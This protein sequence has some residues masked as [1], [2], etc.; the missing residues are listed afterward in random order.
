MDPLPTSGAA[1]PAWQGRVASLEDLAACVAALGVLPLQAPAPWPALAAALAPGVTLTAAW[2]WAGTL[3]DRREVFSGRVLPGLAAGCLAT[4][5]VF[6]LA[7]A[8]GP[9]SDP[10]VAYSR[11]AFGITG[12]AVVDLLRTRGPLTLQQIRLGLGQHKRFLIHDTPQVM[13]TL[14]RALVVVAVGPEYRAAAAPAAPTPRPRSRFNPPPSP[15]LALRAWDLTLRWAPPAALAAADRLREE[16]GQA[17]ALLR[18]HLLLLH[19][20]ASAADLDTLLGEDSDDDPA[21][22]R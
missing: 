1:W 10:L 6:S 22:P 7:F 13:D 17:R 18:T 5:P 20:Q 12:K 3:V 19:A 21:T 16:R 14:E 11:G 2:A 15:D 8:R 4:L 9:G